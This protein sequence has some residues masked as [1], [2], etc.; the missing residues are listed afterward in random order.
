MNNVDHPL[1]GPPCVLKKFYVED[2]MG[3]SN[4]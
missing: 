4:S 2:M 3:E 1:D